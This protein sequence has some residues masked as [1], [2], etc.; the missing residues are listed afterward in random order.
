MVWEP[1]VAEA[2]V[3]AA[4]RILARHGNKPL[5]PGTRLYSTIES[6]DED[7]QERRGEDAVA[8][9]RTGETVT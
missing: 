7:G 8:S 2:A 4:V 3:T 9:G 6:V 5:V 1:E